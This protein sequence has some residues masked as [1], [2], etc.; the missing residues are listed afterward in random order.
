ML[1]SLVNPWCS[2]LADVTYPIDIAP[3][4]SA[5][6]VGFCLLTHGSQQ[7][8]AFYDADRQMT[9]GV[10]KLDEATWHFAKLPE[11]IGWDSHNYIAM[12]IDDAD[13]IHLSGNMHASPLQYFRTTKP[14]DVDSFI[15]IDHMVGSNEASVTYP[16]FMRG[17]ENKLIF[18]YR[19]GRSGDGNQI[20]NVYD[21]AT[22][23]WKRLL[24]K[25][26]TDGE[27]HRNAYFYGPVSGPDG[28]FHLVW[29]WRESPDCSSCHDVS[30][31]R[32]RDLIHWEDSA[33]KAL[34]LPITLETG[35]IVD[36]VPQKGGTINNDVKVGFDSNKQPVVT[37]VKYDTA[38]NS[39]L[40]CARKVDGAWKSVQV[41]NWNYRW[42][43]S[44]GGSI[45]FDI[46]DSPVRVDKQGRLIQP[47]Y[48]KKFGSGSIQLSPTTLKPLGTVADDTPRIPRDV[49][50]PASTFPGMGVQTGSDSGKDPN[51]GRRFVL[52]WDTLA[53]NRDR[54]PEGPLPPPSMLRLYEVK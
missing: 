27:G 11:H 44:G 31:A 53:P 5:F 49:V 54:Q 45:I 42:D 8:V 17:P 4:C 21:S 47:F 16:I 35:D 9:V 15:K 18:T 38:G 3:V 34:A 10:R 1:V 43:F 46:N 7:F 48:H 37:Y 30:Y 32:S 14:L 26:L 50:K 52:R 40:Y 20:F 25:P 19:D 12:T 2:A 28:Y 6:P 23:S 36:H 22:G 24:D 33:G 39:Q 41:T 51:T 13:M 29:V